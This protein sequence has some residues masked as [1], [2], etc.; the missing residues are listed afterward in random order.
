MFQNYHNQGV[1]K[2]RY[3]S[4]NSLFI[5]LLRG[6]FDLGN[7]ETEE[8]MGLGEYDKTKNKNFRQRI[9][10]E[11]SLKIMNKSLNVSVGINHLPTLL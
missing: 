2:L 10:I 6:T 8:V 3:L 11:N 1:R 5:H 9:F 7:P 4:N